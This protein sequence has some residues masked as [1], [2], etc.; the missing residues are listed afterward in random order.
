MNISHCQSLVALPTFAKLANVALLQVGYM[1]SLTSLASFPLLTNINSLS[2]D[3]LDGITAVSFPVLKTVTSFNVSGMAKL[4]DLEGFGPNLKISSS[5]Q[6]CNI[7]M[8]GADREVWKQ[9]HAP[10][11][12]FGSCS[13]GCLGW[14]TC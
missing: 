4:A 10:G 1:G 8:K 5:V 13:N 6:V 9:K 7:L 12:N 2:L 3:S 11:L 14:G